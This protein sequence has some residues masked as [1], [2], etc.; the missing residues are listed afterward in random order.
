V[1]SAVAGGSRIATSPL[2]TVEEKSIRPVLVLDPKDTSTQTVAEFGDATSI[3]ANRA[4]YGVNSWSIDTNAAEAFDGDPATSWWVG[5]VF[6][7][8]EDSVVSVDFKSS[9]FVDRV[10]V[11]KAVF[12]AAQITGAEVEVIGVDGGT[13]VTPIVFEGSIGR[14][15]L[16]VEAKALKVRITEINGVEGKFGFQE[17]EVFGQ[18]GPLDLTQWIRV[19]TDVERLGASITPTFAF[20]RSESEAQSTYLRREFGVPVSSGYRFTASLAVPKA[21]DEATL[22]RS[23]RDWF[24]ID[25]VGSAARITSFDSQTRIATL[26]GCTE[27]RLNAGTHRVVAIGTSTVNFYSFGFM[28]LAGMKS[29]AVESV[30]SQRVSAS[31]HQVSIPADAGWLSMLLPAHPGW[32]MNAQGRT[33]DFL[34]MNGEMGWSVAQGDAVTATITFRPQRMYLI[35]IAVAAMAVFACIVLLFWRRREPA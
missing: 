31:K 1:A 19:P 21:I 8:A 30:D 28:P 16:G 4:G 6:A 10:V 12:D 11:T 34:L 20:A 15:P 17:I 9:T 2:M 3:S 5:N 22:D 23:C 18:D 27:L 7:P 32:S 26:E 14:A 33:A 13:S 29:T 35:A 24:T 25:G